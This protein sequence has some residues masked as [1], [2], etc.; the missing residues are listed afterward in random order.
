MAFIEHDFR[1]TIRD[2]NDKTELTNKGILSFFEDIGGLHSD[3]AGYGL[4]DIEE[5]K[6]SWVLLN[7]KIKVL[8]RILYNGEPIK[9]KTWSRNAVRAC[10]FRDFEL[11]NSKGELCVIGSSKWTLV[12]LENG[13]MRI[14]PELIEKY[15]PEDK[16]V[17][18]D[19]DFKKIQ[20][21]AEYSS[22]Y[23]YTVSRRDIDINNH[24]HN[25]NYLDLAYEALPREIYESNSFDNV[26]IMYKNGAKLYEKLKCFYSNVSNEHF[27]TIKSEDEKILHAIV[28]LF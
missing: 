27:V 25:L 6:I 12:H 5:T 21:P 17:F 16:A 19:F 9:V 13:L 28:K 22:V 26:E 7:W 14:T 18:D 2:I 4:K 3:I 10:T 8:K 11:Y 1:L 24:M 23:E 20:E 15:N